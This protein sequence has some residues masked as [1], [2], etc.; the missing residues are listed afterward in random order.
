MEK[1]YDF[2]LELI[3]IA[4]TVLIALTFHE[5][6]HGFI[7]YKLGDPTAKYMGRL[8]L[9]PIRHIDPLGAL[10]MFLAHFG[11]AKPVP[12]D[13]T[14][15]KHPKRDLALS[16]LA[17]PVTNFLL[18]IIGCFFYALAYRFLPFYYESEVTA[19][20]VEILFTFIMYFGIL[21]FSLALFNFLPIPPLDGSKIMYAFLPPSANNWCKMHERE[22]SLVFFVVLFV[23]YRFLNGMLTG[24]L[25]D[26]VL[27]IFN[28][29]ANLFFK[30]FI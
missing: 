10:C 7:A 20:L 9:N 22:I 26:G 1:I 23:D 12:I 6:A 3:I 16:A 19:K 14:N 11:W 21:N 13:I 28:T 15:F 2:L 8:S 24:F 30:I 4:P 29:F 25:H 27:Y 17:G 18:G 5:C